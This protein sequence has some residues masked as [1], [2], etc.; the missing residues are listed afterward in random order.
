V[1]DGHGGWRLPA[2]PSNVRVLSPMPQALEQ[3]PLGNF[4]LGTSSL[5]SP[6]LLPDGSLG[7]L[8]L[9]LRGKGVARLVSPS[10]IGWP[11]ELPPRWSDAPTWVILRRG[12]DGLVLG[13]ARP[14][15]RGKRGEGF[16]VLLQLEEPLPEALWA[17]LSAEANASP[18]PPAAELVCALTEQST[19]AERLAALRLFVQR[20]YGISDA[21]EVDSPLA[22][23]PLRALR[24]LLGDRRAELFPMH[25]F[26]TPTLVD[27]KV[28][29]YVECQG[30]CTWATDADDEDPPVYVRFNQE[31]KVESPSLSAFLLQM[32][33]LAGAEYLSPRR[34][35]TTISGSSTEWEI[36]SE[37]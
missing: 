18:P 29:F 13:R 1:G 7:I 3:G 25:D 30:V 2:D 11:R 6:Y 26:V 16:R 14:L 10:E 34:D 33:M 31:W 8:I 24:T 27:G 20:W 12:D 5:D 37:R 32:V 9:S 35:R 17:T 4:G 28:I 22:P 15:R 23:A 19:V 21:A 36:R